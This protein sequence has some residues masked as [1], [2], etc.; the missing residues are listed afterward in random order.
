[1]ILI[2]FEKGTT[3]TPKAAVMEHL[4]FSSGAHARKKVMEL[5]SKS[6]TFQF[7][8]HAFD[9]SSFLLFFLMFIHSPFEASIS[10]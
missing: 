4:A 7:A 8:A 2:S 5:N 6:R 3:G 9:G 1:L 10:L